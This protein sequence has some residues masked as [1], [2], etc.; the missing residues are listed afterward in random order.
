[1]ARLESTERARLPASAFAYVDAKGRRR[2]PIHD[3][4]HVRNALARFGQVRF[5][6]ERAREK[7]RTRLLKAARR[8][9]IVP[10]GFISG[11]L[12]SERELGRRRANEPAHLP[13]GFVTM[14]M[15]DVEG[16][17]AL[18]HRLGDRYHELIT[19]V[20]KIL[21]ATAEGGDGHVVETRADEFFGVFEKPAS[22]VTAAV[23]LQRELRGRTWGDGVDVRLRVGLHSG[24]PTR[25]APNYIGIA[26]NTAARVCAAA[27][28]G[29]VLV[30]GDTREACRG[31]NPPGVRFLDLGPYRLRG[32]PEPVRLCQ[33]AAKGLRARFPAPRGAKAV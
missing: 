23:A 24:H 7:A 6:D 13:A 12:E 18:V 30:S 14:L 28:G 2:L 4:A 16:S 26:V 32:L 21:R 1:M 15:T 9:G 17:T 11:Q 27:H 10:V 29:Q 31:S 8:Y 19:E 3:E 22:A 5:E 33:V 20:W 25:S